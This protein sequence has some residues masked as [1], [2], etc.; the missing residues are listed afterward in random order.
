MDRG[1]KRWLLRL[2]V[3]LIGGGVMLLY[4]LRQ[5][6]LDQLTIVNQSG[7]PIVDLKITADGETTT[8]RKIPNGQTRPVPSVTKADQSVTMRWQLQDG[9]LHSYT[10]LAGE[11]LKINITVDGARQQT[12][13]QH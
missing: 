5:Q 8:F 3:V 13:N 9:S 1:R 6:S 7:Q 11:Q 10:G 12:G 2:T 4:A